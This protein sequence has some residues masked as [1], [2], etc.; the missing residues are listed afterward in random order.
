MA[1][2]PRSRLLATYRK[3]TSIA[4]PLTGQFL[5][6]RL[7]RGK[8]DEDRLPERLGRPGRVRPKGPLVWVHAASVGES[9]SV[10]PLIR[11]LGRIRP[12]A[13]VL[14]TTG[15]VTSGR[16]MVERLPAN[17][18]HQF[19]PLDTPTAVRAF[20]DYWQPGLALWVESE[21]WP[22]MLF[23]TRERGIPVA[24]VNAR[25]SE[26]SF[27]N[28]KRAKRAAAELL[29]SFDICLAQDDDVADKLRQLGARHVEVPGNLKLVGD[30]LPYDADVLMELRAAVGSR[31]K[32]LWA[33]THEGEEQLAAFTHRDLAAQFP[34]LLTIIVPRHPQR[35]P[36]IAAS[37]EGLF[38]VARRSKGELPSAETELYIADTLGELGVFFRLCPLAVMGG[39][40]V[41][42]G[43]QNPLEPARL[44]A[45]VLSGP[46]IGNFR[47]IFR[48]LVDGGGAEVLASNDQLTERARFLLDNDI[49][50]M[51]RGQ[52]AQAVAGSKEPLVRTFEFLAPYLRAFDANARA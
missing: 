7:A 2:T 32:L 13:S 4:E 42:H 15:T 10:L 50:T 51:Q 48:L 5:R 28:W 44:G 39:S 33:S 52:A 29:D 3:M 17:A 40:F 21:L 38:R 11:E 23:E 12:D 8:E 31:P 27:R 1:E 46:H 36:Q 37:L 34:R 49:E 45:A 6:Q 47:E 43:G 18:F 19:V 26:G 16:M 22:N 24:L 35:G 25:M 9:V 30:P 14:V 20:L 41:P